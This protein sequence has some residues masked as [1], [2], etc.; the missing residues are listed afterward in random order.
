MVSCDNTAPSIFSLSAAALSSENWRDFLE[1]PR[2]V[3]SS[4]GFPGRLFP[5]WRLGVTVVGSSRL[6]EHS[7]KSLS[8]VSLPV[9]ESL[10]QVTA[11]WINLYNSDA[12][13]ILRSQDL[14][15]RSDTLWLL[16]NGNPIDE[17]QS[18]NTVP[19]LSF[20]AD[21][22]NK[23]SK[24]ALV[25]EFSKEH[26][27]NLQRSLHPPSFFRPRFELPRKVHGMFT[28]F[29]VIGFDFFQ[30]DPKN[31]LGPDFV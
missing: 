23:F 17:Q 18:A 6:L 15:T 24:D 31:Q 11:V 8:S 1:L 27:Q 4:S 3:D 28:G 16:I 19:G 25:P 7:C 21:F 20:L 26:E 14:Q 30:S 5:F 13:L 2:S 22:E 12:F 9:A 29:W 10:L